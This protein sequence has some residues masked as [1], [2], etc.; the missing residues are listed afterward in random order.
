MVVS[1]CLLVRPRP[2]KF[3]IPPEV[4]QDD[5]IRKFT[6]DRL[7]AQVRL[8]LVRIAADLTHGSR[9]RK[10]MNLLPQGSVVH[11]NSVKNHDGKTVM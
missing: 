6:R 10:R 5:L 11:A 3:V 9:L 1:E 4:D 8:K 7:G 2:P